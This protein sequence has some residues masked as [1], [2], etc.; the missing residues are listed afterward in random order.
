M[1]VGLTLIKLIRLSLFK[2]ESIKFLSCLSTILTYKAEKMNKQFSRILLIGGLGLTVACDNLGEIAKGLEVAQEVIEGSGS[3]E[4]ASLT[5]D[6]IISGLKE[7][8]SFGIRRGAEKVSVIDGFF[9]NVEIKVPFPEEVKKV[10][11]KARQFGLNNQ[12]DKFVLT[13]NRAAEEASKEAVPVFVEAIK[14]MSITD[15]MGILKGGDHAATDYLKKVT[16][17]E[18][19]AKFKPVV[20]NAIQKVELTKYWNP[21]I[22]TYNRVPGVEKKN[23][24]LENYV[25]EKALSGLFLMVAKEEGNIR[26]DPAARATDLLKKVFANQ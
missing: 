26:K 17:T 13:L 12:V 22:K 3:N 5:N 1:V 9:S 20:Q 23:P 25:T 21:V 8:L 7:A 4:S 15:A 2:P 10:E 18:L 11:E 6:E 19:Q 24:D 16:T 14:S